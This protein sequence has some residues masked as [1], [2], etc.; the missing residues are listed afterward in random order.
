MQD[1]LFSETVIYPLNDQQTLV[2]RQGEWGCTDTV[3]SSLGGQS[4]NSCRNGFAGGLP[5][6]MGLYYCVYMYGRVRVHGSDAEVEQHIKLS[7]P[8]IMVPIS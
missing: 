8:Q 2:G 1:R 5:A 6:C 7:G 3:D 4:N